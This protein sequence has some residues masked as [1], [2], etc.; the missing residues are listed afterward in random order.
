MIKK[1]PM[2]KQVCYDAFISY[3]HLDEDQEVAERLQVLLEKQK[4]ADVHTGKERRL[5]I[6]R[7]RSDLPAGGDLGAD[8]YA[9]LE[10]S[11]FLIILYS[12]KTKESIWCMKELDYFRSLH[13][14]TNQN[15]LPMI[16]EGE[17]DEVFPDVL[18]RETRQVMDENG[19][20]QTVQIEVE[21]LGADVRAESLS[22][23]LTKLKK[24]EY[25]RIAAP[26]IGCSYDD[27]YRRKFRQ[28]VR[29]GIF[30]T[31]FVLMIF[32]LMFWIF[33]Q[34]RISELQDAA[35][36]SV[37]AEWCANEEDW[38]SALMYY[39]EALSRNG[40][41][42]SECSAAMILLQ[43]QQWPFITRI[44]DSHYRNE[45][46][47]N[48]DISELEK[49]TGGWIVAVDSTSNYYLSGF[50]NDEYIVCDSNG[51]QTAFLKNIGTLTWDN[52]YQECWAFYQRNGTITLYHPADDAYCTFSVGIENY[53]PPRV[54]LAGS[55]ACLVMDD[56]N[57]YLTLYQLD[58]ARG[59]AQLL[60][61]TT[62]SK[63]FAERYTEEMFSNYS[64]EI[65]EY[66]VPFV[67]ATYQFQISLEQNAVIIGR[68]VDDTIDSAWSD[69]VVLQLSDLACKRV[70]SDDHYYLNQISLCGD[71][72][73]FALSYGNDSAFVYSGGYVAVYDF[74]GKEL[75]RTENEN[76][77]YN[78]AEFC[79]EGNTEIILWGEQILQFWDYQ[80][81]KEYAA[82]VK[83]GKDEYGK[84]IRNV[85]CTEDS[86]CIINYDNRLIY[87][88][89]ASFTADS[90]ADKIVGPEMLESDN[91]S[92]SYL[93]D[94]QL[95]IRIQ[96]IEN[97]QI[98]VTLTDMDGSFYDEKEIN[99]EL[100]QT[101]KISVLNPSVCYLFFEP[102][103]SFYRIDILP[104]KKLAEPQELIMVTSR[105]NVY[106]TG[107]GVVFD[108]GRE[109][110]Y[111]KNDSIFY[112]YFLGRKQVSG[113]VRWFASNM[114]DLL[115]LNINNQNHNIFEYWNVK[116]KA[117]VDI[118]L[119][120]DEI[121]TDAWFLTDDTFVYST[122]TGIIQ[123]Q[124]VAD[125]PDKQARKALRAI[126]GMTI[127]DGVAEYVHEVFD[128]NLGNWGSLKVS[129]R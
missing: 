79:S 113:K 67:N 37:M 96:A 115:I 123:L 49:A 38:Q 102:L 70:I 105:K 26:I 74:T 84:R 92:L 66:G 63:L 57:D 51:N 6:F 83:V 15:I 90:I 29:I 71:D 62:L 4:I 121:I 59:S 20:N 64:E 94:N 44:E 108:G 80:T 16:L 52:M 128:G 68:S 7:D 78:G 124:V 120:K 100:Y 11:R 34:R 77:A 21:P 114:N 24:T 42:A 8:I 65:K 14:N 17:P 28:Q 95:V 69:A 129:I 55:Q 2:K 5:Y 117:Y 12:H 36:Y 89:I 53:L 82:S 116:T 72:S 109:L 87:Y 93:I 73:C 40:S 97:N 18:K 122:E 23:K 30:V 85:I 111:Y 43:K 76:L 56:Y 103:G 107:N 3:R 104:S 9:A 22:R 106:F 60:A 45:I 119:D 101:C 39:N 41:L 126:C 125:I 75:F 19:E 1:S 58:F 91:I 110:W 50:Q 13:G 88:S 25:M 27:L 61:S 48:V 112:E 118:Q 99:A 47:P 86:H 35:T 81:G 98:R 127:K 32:F 10:N 33:Y 54:I 31:A 46:Y